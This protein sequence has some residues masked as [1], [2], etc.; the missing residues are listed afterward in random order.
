MLKQFGII[1]I[2]A[3]LLI[4]CDDSF[5]PKTSGSGDVSSGGGGWNLGGQQKFAH[6]AEPQTI[7]L[8][9]FEGPDHVDRAVSQKNYL[10]DTL[11]WHDVY[12]V[13]ED[14]HSILYM[15]SYGSDGASQRQIQANLAKAKNFRMAN[16]VQPFVKAIVIAKPGTADEGPSEW[17]LK[18]AKG[19]YSVLV[20]IQYDVP[21]SGYYGRKQRAVMDCRNLRKQGYDAYY[22]HGPYKS[23]VAVG[24]FPETSIKTVMVKARH[25]ITHNEFEVEKKV[26]VDPKMKKVFQDF[27]EMLICGNT[28][29]TVEIYYENGRPKR[30]AVTQEPYP[31]IIPNAEN[32]KTKEKEKQSDAGNRSTPGGG[33]NNIRLW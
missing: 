20:D 31:I 22:F 28:E 5:A 26:I 29:K 25:P 24:T 1:L 13:H 27:P 6:D 4:G 32:K 33:N 15:G 14:D 12:V 17:N 9:L 19:Y 8:Q 23:G 16:G 3:L 21:Q 2:F 30:H 11:Q 7:L 18:N 10:A